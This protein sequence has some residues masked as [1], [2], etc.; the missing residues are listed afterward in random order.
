MDDLG[1]IDINLPRAIDGRAQGS[2]DTSRYFPAGPRRLGGYRTMILAR[3]RPDGDFE[4]SATQ[5]LILDSAA[6]KILS[7]SVLPQIFGLI[8][9][10]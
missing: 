7:P 4:R 8:E 5:D 3:L 6:A 10:T 1:R 9:A 2:R